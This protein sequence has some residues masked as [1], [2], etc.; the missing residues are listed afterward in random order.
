MLP[1]SSGW[2]EAAWTSENLVSCHK[3]SRRHNPEDLDFK[4]HSHKSLTTRNVA[5]CCLLCIRNE[6]RSGSEMQSSVM[7]SDTEA[8]IVRR[9]HKVHATHC[10]VIIMQLYATK[11]LLRPFPSSIPVTFTPPPADRTVFRFGDHLRNINKS[12]VYF[13]RSHTSLNVN[14]ELIFL[15]LS[16]R[17]T[18]CFS[19]FFPFV[20]EADIL[21]WYINIFKLQCPHRMVITL[22]ADLHTLGIFT[23]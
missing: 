16:F 22:T 19:C 10:V 9:V 3:T 20:N 12:L 13:H 6:V 2:S 4:H 23:N 21:S 15:M 8:M 1:P 17:I 5:K 7:M 11:S 14:T 18:K